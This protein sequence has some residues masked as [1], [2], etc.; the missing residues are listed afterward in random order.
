MKD[1]SVL[2]M[3]VHFCSLSCTSPT[4]IFPFIFPCTH[5]EFEIFT[6]CLN[7]FIASGVFVHVLWNE[8]SIFTQEES[9]LF[10]LTRLWLEEVQSIF[11]FLKLAIVANKNILIH[12]SMS[13][14]PPVFL[15]NAIKYFL[16][17][18]KGAVHHLNQ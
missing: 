16:K 3:Y 5:S 14:Y 7:E 4:C 13:T 9:I 8:H 2:Q 6:L 11:Q 1:G 10:Y 15:M 12:G 18:F 17:F